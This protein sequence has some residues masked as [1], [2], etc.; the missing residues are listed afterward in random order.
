MEAE[1]EAEKGLVAAIGDGGLFDALALAET[2]RG[3]RP[4]FFR[5]LVTGGVAGVDVHPRVAARGLRFEDRLVLSGLGSVGAPLPHL[6]LQL[7]RFSGGLD[8]EDAHVASL[9][10]EGS[11]ASGINMRN[12]RVTF[13]LRG[14]ALD[15]I[16]EFRLH[17]AQIGGNLS[18]NGAVIDNRPRETDAER[19]E[20]R[21]AA[22]ASDFSSL[23]ADGAQI[24]G[25]VY[26]RPIPMGERH[27]RFTTFGNLRFPGARIAGDVSL[28]GARLVAAT[29]EIDGRPVAIGRA[30]SFDRADIGGG[31]FATPAQGHWL[32]TYGE[33]SVSGARIRGQLALGAADL[34]STG[35][36][37][38]D[39]GDTEVQSVFLDGFAGDLLPADGSDEAAAFRF[40]PFNA[41]GEIRLIGTR[42][43]GQV[44]LL[45]SVL[46]GPDDSFC[47]DNATIDGGLFV[48]AH[49]AAGERF[50]VRLSGRFSLSGATVQRVE[51]VGVRLDPAQP[52]PPIAFRR[53]IDMTG[54]TVRGDLLM[55]LDP[56]SQGL[57]TLENAELGNLPN[58][59]AK[60][61][62][63]PPR[64]APGGPATG[65]LLEIDEL[66]YDRADVRRPDSLS[67]GD[68]QRNTRDSKLLLEWLDRQ[69]VNGAAARDS[70]RPQPFEQAARLL[71]QKG[72]RYGAGRIASSKRQL[73]RRTGVDAGLALI[74]NYLFW[75]F[76]DYGFSPARALGWG[77]GFILLGFVATLG[78]KSVDGLVAVRS[79][80]AF[81]V[82][83]VDGQMMATPRRLPAA[84]CRVDSFG[85][86]LDSFLPLIDLG[87]DRHC[88]IS[89]ELGFQAAGIA[90]LL[91][92]LYAFIG[93]IF[94]PVAALTFAGVLRS[95]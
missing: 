5:A 91:R 16:G 71:R 73:Q 93:L 40:Q 58:I 53:M 33:L 65:V 24:G 95:E 50:P 88:E 21:L 48:K 61:W 46:R 6:V 66:T 63:N 15:V 23:T 74:G 68:L 43:H 44:N 38:L 64:Q 41:Y 34:G 4:E 17:N 76:F 35:G 27:R 13:D 79:Q 2:D 62:G 29:R 9:S 39:L 42:V 69:F 11:D 51:L 92:F 49:H 37:S 28:N 36:L 30:A 70:F 89:D 12:I 8:M 52:D 81:V 14:G 67:A 84:P 94:L 57:V 1:T 31:I 85:Y 56:E 47:A 86:A 75:L 3:V 60:T 72:D 22:V 82:S 78:L 19:G 45:G 25:D 83:E 80:P 20:T 18:L 32:D 77:I 26:M 54:A 55:A 87:F 7:C 10:L 59:D 90:E